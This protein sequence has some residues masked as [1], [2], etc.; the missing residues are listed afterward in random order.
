MTSP[1]DKNLSP[2]AQFF[3]ADAQPTP[4]EQLARCNAAIDFAL[5]KAGQ[6]GLEFLFLWRS[7]DWESIQARFPDFV[8]Y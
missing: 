1:N 7:G 8:E 6:L 2:L 4:S 5:D 3:I